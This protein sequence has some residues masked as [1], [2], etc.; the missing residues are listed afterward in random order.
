MFDSHVNGDGAPEI[1]VQELKKKIAELPAGSFRMIDVRRPEEYTGELG[2]IEGSELVTLETDFENML[3]RWGTDE[4]YVF[5][6]RSGRRSTDAALYA[7]QK[8]FKNVYNLEG[9]MIDWNES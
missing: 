3:P 9:G 6:C 4:T 1:K 8:G 2:H 7:M 5:I